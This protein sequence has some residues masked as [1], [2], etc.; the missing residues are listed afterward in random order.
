MP[1][2]VT[3]TTEQYKVNPLSKSDVKIFD[4][5]VLSLLSIYGGVAL[6]ALA[7]V[8]S[9]FLPAEDA[10]ILFQYSRNLAEHGAIT[11]LANGPHVEGATD[12][13]WMV[14]VAAGI[15]LHIPPLWFS[16]GVNVLSLILLAVIL[17]KI[18]EVQVSFLRLLAIVGSIALMPQ[19]L[20]A[21]SGFAVLPDAVLLS[22]FVLFVMRGQLERASLTAFV[23]CLFRP[24][25][26]VFTIPLLAYVIC[27]WTAAMEEYRYDRDI[28]CC[29]GNCLLFVAVDIFRGTVSPSISGQG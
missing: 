25:A 10:I 8:P 19:I 27:S 20:A 2:E 1:I 7:F 26:V 16:A 22:T 24:D 17:L 28:V 18:A 4:R 14:L 6:V 11:F 21:A 9:R 15:R 23:F 29:S 12:F 3:S 13:G 5:T